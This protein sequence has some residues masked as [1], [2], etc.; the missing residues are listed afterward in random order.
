[1][2]LTFWNVAFNDASVKGL[3][4]T[5]AAAAAAAGLSSELFGPI[6]PLL[7]K[8]FP[9][10]NDSEFTVEPGETLTPYGSGTP[11]SDPDLFRGERE[12]EETVMRSQ[13]KKRN[14]QC[15]YVLVME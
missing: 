14:F 10:P 3:S 12:R 4:A 5:A 6:G 9:F 13:A 7:S 1:M 15:K 2:T 11:T 8:P